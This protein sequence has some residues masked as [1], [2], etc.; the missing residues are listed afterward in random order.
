MDAT[1]D[2]RISQNDALAIGV[3]T[4]IFSLV[5]AIVFADLPMQESETVAVIRGINPELIRVGQEI[6]IYLDDRP[7][8]S[9]SV[10]RPN[11]GRRAET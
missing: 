4:S 5:S 6:R 10:G 2:G 8:H 1:G 11:R 7:G 9:A 3:N